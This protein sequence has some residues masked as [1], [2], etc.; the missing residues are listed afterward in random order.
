VEPISDWVEQARWRIR[1][2]LDKFLKEKNV[3]NEGIATKIGKNLVPFFTTIYFL[4]NLHM[5][6]IS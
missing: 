2:K 6:Q 1:T 5:F 4:R 3:E